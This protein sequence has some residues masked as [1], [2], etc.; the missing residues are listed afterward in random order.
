MTSE[1]GSFQWSNWRWS[2]DTRTLEGVE[3][4]FIVCT[5]HKNLVY[6]QTTKHLNSRQA[7]WALFFGQFSFTLTYCPGSNNLKP[8]ALFQQFT[9]EEP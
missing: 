8:D 6:S 4:P 5:G 3:Q 9:P 7:R 2:G 1:I